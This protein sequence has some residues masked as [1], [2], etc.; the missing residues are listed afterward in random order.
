MYRIQK[1]IGSGS[2]GSVFTVKKYT[3]NRIY[4]MKR[5]ST[6]RM[7]DKNKQQLIN[8]IKIIK[9]CKC[10]YI[11]PFVDCI[12]NPTNIEIVTIYAKYGDFSKIIK[13]RVKKFKENLIWSYFIQSCLGIEYLHKNNIIHRDIKSANIFLAKEDH[14]LIGDFGISKVLLNNKELT[15]TCI[16]T[17]FYMTPEML[18]HKEYDKSIDIWGLGCFLFELISFRPPFSGY[19]LRSL[20]NNINTSTFNLNL[21]VYNHIYNKDLVEFPKKIIINDI[22]KRM[23][24]KELLNCKEIIEHHYLI[25]YIAYVNIDIKDINEKFKDVSHREWKYIIRSLKFD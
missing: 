19:S 3:S 25:P 6:Y 9:Y 17:P 24:I 22:N 23:N 12:Y 11:I 20:S 8:E 10:P 18:Q 1:C 4:A 7:N 2:Y 5:V 15:N 13:K 14:V 16:G 21:N